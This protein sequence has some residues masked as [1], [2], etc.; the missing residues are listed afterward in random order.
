MLLPDFPHPSQ[1]DHR[2]PVLRYRHRDCRSKSNR[3]SRPAVHLD[4]QNANPAIRSKHPHPRRSQMARPRRCSPKKGLAH[5]LASTGMRGF[6]FVKG[7]VASH[8]ICVEGRNPWL[9]QTSDALKRGSYAIDAGC[10]GRPLCPPP[11]HPSIP[12]R[13]FPAASGAPAGRMAS[14]RIPGVPRLRAPPPRLM[15]AG[16]PGR[17]SA[18]LESLKSPPQKVCP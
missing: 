12:I 5:Q 10:H 9:I 18:P 8:G 15:A 6:R 2:M 14:V 7:V 3:S 13:R 11:P 16:P 1:S 4:S 17:K